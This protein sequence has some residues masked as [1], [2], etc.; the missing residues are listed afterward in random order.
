MASQGPPTFQEKYG[1]CWECTI[2]ECSWA[3]SQGQ[4]SK[5]PVSL[6]VLSFLRASPHHHHA[7]VSLC[8]A[9]LKSTQKRPLLLGTSS[10][11]HLLSD[12]ETKCYNFKD[13]Y[14]LFIHPLP[15]NKNKNACHFLFQDKKKKKE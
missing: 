7:K 1:I 4:P 15:Q 14:P 9:K 8:I 5:T 10:V 11:L 12:S 3:I 2:L 6:A 13:C